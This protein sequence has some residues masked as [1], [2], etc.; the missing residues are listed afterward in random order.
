[1]RVLVDCFNNSSVAEKGEVLWWWA[2]RWF[3]ELGV[4]G[5]LEGCRFLLAL[6]VWAVC[7]VLAVLGIED[8]FIGD[9][10]TSSFFIGDFFIDYFWG[11]H[12]GGK[13]F[14]IK[15]F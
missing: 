7:E 14:V 2:L 1:M 4:L 5:E 8:F 9:L 12:F 13:H 15:K 11:K 6:A 3:E 10:F